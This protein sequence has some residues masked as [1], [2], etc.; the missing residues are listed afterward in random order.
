M[1]RTTRRQTTL[2]GHNHGRT[3]PDDPPRT[4][5]QAV[6]PTGFD[7]DVDLAHGRRRLA[8]H[9]PRPAVGGRLARAR[10]ATRPAGSG[11][12]ASASRR[13]PAPGRR[14]C[15]LD[16]LP[17]GVQCPASRALNGLP[18]VGEV[19]DW[20]SQAQRGQ[21]HRGVGRRIDVL[22]CV[23]GHAWHC[24]MWPGRARP[25]PWHPQAGCRVG[26]YAAAAGCPGLP[27]R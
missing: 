16:L 23:A 22:A 17:D 12:A 21:R 8:A 14:Q 13:R 20:V 9:R 6:A 15:G 24:A 3:T 1:A 7:P 18:R 4:Y 10:A 25:G 11:V 26:R 5:G 19:G 27:G 2:R